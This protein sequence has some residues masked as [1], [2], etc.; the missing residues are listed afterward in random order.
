MKYIILQLNPNLSRV[1]NVFID[2]IDVFDSLFNVIVRI[3][4]FS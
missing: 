4:D 3:D 2:D 1:D